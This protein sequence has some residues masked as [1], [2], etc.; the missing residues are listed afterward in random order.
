MKYNELHSLEKFNIENN[1]TIFFSF[2]QYFLATQSPT[3]KR[4]KKIIH[5]LLQIFF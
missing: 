4:K 3:K 5:F 1:L 2:V